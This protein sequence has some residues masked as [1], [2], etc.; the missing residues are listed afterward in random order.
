[1][2]S[3]VAVYEMMIIPERVASVVAR[4]L[5]SCN[6]REPRMTS[7]GTAHKMKDSDAQ[8]AE[9]CQLKNEVPARL[10]VVLSNGRVCPPPS[11]L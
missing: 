3:G 5:N 8:N 7:A 9:K 4:S 6:G 1:M 2:T 10:K 11:V